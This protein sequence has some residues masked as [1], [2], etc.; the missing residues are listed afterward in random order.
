MSVLKWGI[1]G[2]GVI[3]NEFA[4]ALNQGKLC[5][6]AVASRTLEKAEAFADEY[7]AHRAFEGYDALI[8]CRDV[9]IVYIATPHN[10]HYEWAKKC[11]LAGKHVLCE[12]AITV[13]GKELEEL[14]AIALD[15]KLVFR[16]AMTIYHMPIYGKLRLM[17][18]ENKPLGKVKTINVVFGSYK[19]YDENNR[20]FSPALAGGALLDIGV[21]AISA[22]RLFMSCA[23]DTVLSTTT[24]APS[25]VDEQIG[26][27]LKN[28][29]DEIAVINIALRA[30]L[31]K[32]AIIACEN[33]YIS[34]D[35]YPRAEKAEIVWT[36]SGRK[37]EICAGDTTMALEY[38]AKRTQDIILKGEPDETVQLTK[39][40]MEIM[41]KVRQ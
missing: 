7:G 31:P 20:F 16:E 38:E 36:E 6:E 9:D 32:R 37:E 25:G 27:V 10:L 18:G 26:I 40:V 15:K 29:F 5:L 34:V 3:A 24:D 21:Y 17:I 1:I 2:T 12:K 13:N 8:K 11:L 14:C 39:D 23:P 41:D 28:R 30:K 33:G 4:Q 35:N 19:P 22:A